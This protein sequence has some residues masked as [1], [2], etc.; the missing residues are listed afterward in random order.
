MQPDV[1]FAR[2]PNGYHFS[3]SGEYEKVVDLPDN[4]SRCPN[5]YH[6]SPDGDCEKVTGSLSSS[7]SAADSNEHI[8]SESSDESSNSSSNIDNNYEN[9]NNTNVLPSSECQG[10]ADCF[11]GKVT[12]IVDGD[13]L[14]I[15]NIRVRLTLVNTPERG[16]A[17]YAGA[18]EFVK[19]V[20]SIGTDALVD[21]DDGQKEGSYDRLIGLVYCG[22]ANDAGNKKRVLLNEVLLQNEYAVLF[23]EFCDKSE[24]FKAAWAQE[25]GC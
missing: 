11:K 5:G 2:C 18:T 22:T 14:D 20:C 8:D 13:T 19:S 7:S 17:G 6:R 1:A 25:Y 24:F 10:Q 23:E 21:E 3:P 16:E 4:L 12:A 9:N 15:D